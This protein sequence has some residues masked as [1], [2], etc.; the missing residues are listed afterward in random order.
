M[1]ILSI[2]LDY[3]T[4]Y[5]NSFF[6]QNMNYSVAEYANLLW[7]YCKN[8]YGEILNDF[9]MDVD[10]FLYINYIFNKSIINSKK[11]VF[12]LYHDAIMHELI[13]KDD[14][15]IINIDLHHDIYYSNSQKSSRYSNAI[16]ESNWVWYLYNK[17]LLKMYTWINQPVSE[18]PSGDFYTDEN[19]LKRSFCKRDDFKFDNYDFDLVFVCLSPQYMAPQH[20]HYFELLKMNYLIHRGQAPVVHTKRFMNFDITSNDS[21]ILNNKYEL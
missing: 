21:G 15:D 20:W 14:L 13:G 11:I 18:M 7:D 8:E 5:Y 6:V 17:N 12:G 2:D 19:E 3:V 1:K 9:R 4:R 10:S 16:T